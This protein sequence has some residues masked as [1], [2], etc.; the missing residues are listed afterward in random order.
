MEFLQRTPFFRLLLPLVCG[1]IAYQHTELYRGTLLALLALSALLIATGFTI[2]KPVLQFQFRW[3]PGLGIFLC[4]FVAGYFIS[5]RYEH[6]NRFENRDK[7]GV[8]SVELTENPAEKCNSYLCRVKTLHY[9][10]TDTS[11]QTRGKA[12]LYIAKNDAAAALESGDRLL[13]K[14]TF[15]KPDGAMNPEGFDYA[16]Y[17]KRQGFG[18]TAYADTAHW[19]KTGTNTAFSI[20]RLAESYQKKLVEIYKR[21]GIEGDEYAVLAALTLGCKDALHP[22]LRQNYSTSGGMHILAV[23]G[24]HVGVVYFVLGFLLS[25]MDKNRRL[26]I[27]KTIII[28]L[29]LWMYALI[30]GLSPSVIRAALMFSFIALGTIFERKAQI[31]NTICVSAFIMLL[32]RP[33]NLFDVGFQLS[34]SAVIS[35]I[36][37]QP[38]I[39]K[40][41]FV[42]NKILR[43][44]WNLLAVSLAAQIGTAPFGLFYFHQFS[45]YFIITN[46][47]AIPAAILIIYTALALL[48]FSSIPYI[49]VWIAFVLKYMLKGLNICIDFIH[50]LPFSTLRFSI[51]LWQITLIIGA[52]IL[53]SAFYKS[54]KF[55]YLSTCLG[56]ILTVVILNLLTKYQTLNTNGIIVYA[57]NKSTHVDF[58]EGQ[59]HYL[60]STDL[61][62]VTFA[63]ENYWMARKLDLPYDI[64]TESWFKDG[65]VEFKGQRICLL[66][67]PNLANKTTAQPLEIDYLIIG[68]G[69]KPKIS[70][71]LECMSPKKIIIDKSIPA[72]YKDQIKKTCRERNIGFYS[73][74]EK[75]A[76]VLKM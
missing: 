16:L 52:I 48:A 23:S 5:D 46:L 3:L 47:V 60:F 8:F 71:I 6:E 18:A 75:G 51:D 17:L 22:E 1:I 28:I 7:A 55:M 10:G 61:S 15:N 2:R 72:W 9:F 34:Y 67:H 42:K 56:C 41:I 63:A 38:A 69:M 62:S 54:R 39:S 21:F 35:I 44:I 58:L 70:Q 37:F 31:Y 30:T 36:Y 64:Y 20:F 50:D 25:F 27:L 66:T 59:Q 19:Q 45:N 57:D 4:M 76:F 11:Y 29:F 43:W 49:P 26:K 33:N 53:A 73:V 65:F 13:V 32:V 14:A 12:I 74:A 68:N 24:L 40:W